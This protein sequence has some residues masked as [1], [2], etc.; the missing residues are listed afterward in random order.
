M[1]QMSIGKFMTMQNG[2]IEKNVIHMDEWVERGKNLAD[3]L[4]EKHGYGYSEVESI[5]DKYY[6]DRD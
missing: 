4:R 6:L 5:I 3:Q 2:F 1:V